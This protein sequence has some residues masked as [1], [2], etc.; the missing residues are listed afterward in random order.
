M[1]KDADTKD[2]DEVTPSDTKGGKPSDTKGK[3]YSEKEVKSL[4]D[5]KHSKLDARIAELDKDNRRLKLVEVSAKD[6]KQEVD[7]LTEQLTRTKAEFAKKDPDFSS[8]FAS[9]EELAKGRRKLK[10]DRTKLEQERLDLHDDIK[11][12]KTG[13]HE[14]AVKAAAKEAN[15]SEELLLTIIPLP[16]EGLDIAAVAGRL[17]KAKAE[18]SEDSEDEDVIGKEGEA[19]ESPWSDWKPDSGQSS[20]GAKEVTDTEL[21]KAAESGNM[22]KYAKLRKEQDKES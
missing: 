11:D 3:T 15:V 2:K 13:K 7:T 21:T 19:T 12:V 16:Y 20:G 10:E 4:L 5:T 8:L 6:S 17:P 18:D 22:D 14:K 9:E 1:P